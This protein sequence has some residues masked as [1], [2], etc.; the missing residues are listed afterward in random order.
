MNLNKLNHTA[1]A[2]EALYYELKCRMDKLLEAK[3]SQVNMAKGN[4]GFITDEYFRGMA[5][6]LEVALSILEAREPQFHDVHYKS[7]WQQ[8]AQGIGGGLG[9]MAQQQ[10]AMSQ[11]QLA[12]QQA[13]W[14]GNQM[15]QGAQNQLTPANLP[16][17]PAS[18]A[19]TP[20]PVQPVYV[21]KGP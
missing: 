15:Y 1:K 5:N 6:G 18:I 21:K 17:A 8:M 20:V 4:N 13:V 11:N 7:Q 2:S 9:Q 16:S 3:E 12:Q 10:N 14:G 19:P